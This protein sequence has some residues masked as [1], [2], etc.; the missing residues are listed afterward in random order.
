VVFEIFYSHNSI[1]IEEKSPDFFTWF[2][3]GYVLPKSYMKKFKVL[4]SSDV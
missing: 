2:N 1:K 3:A 4:K